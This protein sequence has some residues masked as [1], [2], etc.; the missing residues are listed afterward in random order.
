MISL[1]PDRLSAVT[2]VA[3]HCDDLAIGAGG[4]LLALCEA[5]P[6]LTVRALV[7]T[8]AGTQREVEEKEALQEFCPG[9]VIHLTVLDLPDARTPSRWLEAKSAV[10]AVRLA[11]ATDLVLAPHRHDAH[12][13]H[14][15]LAEITG[16]EFRDHLVL[17]Y[18]ILKY[19]SDI[20]AVDTYVPL[21]HQLARRK[22]SLLRELYPSQH[23]HG[24]YDDEVFMG[25]LRLR[26]VQCQHRY[27]EGFVVDK[28]VV[29][30]TPVR[31]EGAPCASC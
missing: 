24:W 10:S 19:E 6:G 20:P 30:L 13:D 31:P 2:A 16:Q 27:A 11:G 17:G 9:A 5:R 18:E 12:Q 3:A 15:L 4:T 28:A 29:D 7:L 22:A 8:G 25:L 21:D 14:R 26:G 1:R 23:E